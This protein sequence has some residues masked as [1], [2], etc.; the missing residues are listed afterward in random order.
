M[1]PPGGWNRL[2]RN[3]LEAEVVECPPPLHPR[4]KAGQ[5]PI[6]AADRTRSV[7][8]DL[9]R[10]VEYGYE[11]KAIVT[12]RRTE[13]RNIVAFHEGSGS[14]EGILAE[15][16]THCRMDCM[17][18][19]TRVGNRS[20]MFAGIPA[21]NPTRELRI[22]IDRRTRGTTPKRAALRC[23][24]GMGTLR[25]TPVRRTGRIIRPG[26]KPIL[27]M[28]GNDSLERE[29]RHALTALNAAA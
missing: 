6:Q 27:P 14:Q 1:V 23:F 10:P 2:F 9:F 29:L 7:E 24:R 26:G 28:S 20:H 21:R 18:V 13:P 11:F 12:N 15:P 17:P 19:G 25:R 5:T 4:R 8:L 16:G 3:P 22:R